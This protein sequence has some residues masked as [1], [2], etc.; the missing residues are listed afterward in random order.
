VD[1]LSSERDY[2]EIEVERVPLE[3]TDED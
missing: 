1:V 3:P 2:E